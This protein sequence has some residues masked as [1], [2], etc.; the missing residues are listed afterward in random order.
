M[1]H[2]TLE[3]YEPNHLRYTTSNKQDGVAVF[4]EIYY[5]DGWQVTIDGEKAELARANY[6]LRALYIPAG[7]HTIE[8]TFDPQSLHTTETMAYAGY[9][10]LLLGVIALVWKKRKVLAKSE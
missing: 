1:A 6:V 8:M 3:S 7:E 4:S 5:P 9:G 2:L 10:L